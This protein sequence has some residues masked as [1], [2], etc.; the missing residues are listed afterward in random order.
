MKT[1][2][3]YFKYLFVC[4]LMCTFVACGDDDDNNNGSNATIE[5]LSSAEI[6]CTGADNDAVT[7]TF[8][9][10]NDWTAIVSHNWIDLSKRTGSAGEQK[11]I[12]TVENNDDFKTRIGTITIKDKA[13]GKSVDIIVTQGEKGSVL[14]FS[15]EDQNGTSL[16]IDNEKQEITAE[17]SVKSNYDYSI[18]ISPDWLT[19][20][21]KGR[22]N[23]GS[24]K[25]VFHADPEKLYA[26]GGYG[27]QA[28][29]VSFAYQAETRTPTTKEYAVK[30]AG[31]TPSMSCDMDPVVLDDM[32][33]DGYQATIHVISNIKWVL[34]NTPSFSDVTY[35]VTNSS[36]N[37][38]EVNTS[39]KLTYNK[40]ELQVEEEN[41]T[42]TFVDAEGKILDYSLSV[43]YPGVGNDY[44]E[45]DNTV[46]KMPDN[47]LYMFEAHGVEESPG[48]YGNI[49]IDFQ[50]KA[51]N[52]NDVAFYIVR[53]N[54][55][56]S[57][58]YSTYI[59]G[60][61]DEESADMTGYQGWG[62]V[63][64]PETDN[65]RAIV[66]TITK[67]LYIKSRGNEWNGS[68]TEDKDR[69]FALFAVSATKYPTF[70]SLFD[71]EGEL[72][73]ELDAK[74][75][76]LGQKKKGGIEDFVCEGLAGQTLTASPSGE[77]F[78]FEYSGID[79]SSEDWG[80]TWYH[81]VEI[82]DGMM[83]KGEYG[84][85]DMIDLTG[86]EM[87]S[88]ENGTGKITIKV[89]SNTTGKARSEKFA[90]CA[91]MLEDAVITYFTI[92]QATK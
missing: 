18:T 89:A 34:G 6:T 63:E 64:D 52:K 78:T 33:G 91:G 80:A 5:L 8:V 38:F 15:T 25:Y 36:V 71:D 65:T 62:F 13:S 21:D 26:A 70:E 28:A 27:E 69:Y 82:V 50:V 83:N 46:F 72:K 3:S 81:G 12:V 17:V 40:A 86:T 67:T 57:P 55:G 75:I 42:L 29:I 2:S 54:F 10:E 11:I 53:Q 47:Q 16:A 24:R 92:E 79:L 88:L 44:V 41:G 22:N 31:I 60:Y 37:F 73:P 45:I 68:S 51:A 23:D 85:G 56:G 7:I 1:T 30:F 20:E 58:I 76:N 77:T 74:Y 49:A 84:A 43:K 4:V 39:V 90:I 35:P 87:G 59:N 9:A 66:E 32:M 14:T 61:G 19:Y 48:Y